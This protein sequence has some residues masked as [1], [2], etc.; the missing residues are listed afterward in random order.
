MGGKPMGAGGGA[1]QQDTTAAAMMAALQAQLSGLQP[2]Q[3]QGEKG[4]QQGGGLDASAVLSLVQ[5]LMQQQQQQQQQGQQQQEGDGGHPLHKSK[6]DGGYLAK[7]E[8]G[9]QVISRTVCIEN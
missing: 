3:P 6:S 7:E 2:S 5:Q 8:G 4:A 1:G 9:K